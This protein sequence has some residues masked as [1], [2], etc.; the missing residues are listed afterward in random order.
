MLLCVCLE[1]FV[2]WILSGVFLLH[3]TECASTLM[4]EEVRSFQSVPANN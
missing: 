2:G 3:S 4:G 1:M